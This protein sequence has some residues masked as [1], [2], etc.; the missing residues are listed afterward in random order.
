[1]A[2]F[3]FGAGATRGCSFVDPKK[4]PC[5]PPL[6]VDFF[7]QLQRVRNKKHYPLIKQVMRDVVDLFGSNF[8]VTM[9]TV[10]TTLEH[11]LRMLDTTG[12]SRD[13]NKKDLRMKKSRLGQAIA[14]VL[15]D[16]LAEKDEEGHSRLTPLECEHHQRFV[17]D[18]LRPGDD[19]VSFNY[20][21]S[22]DYALKGNGDGKWN[23]R[24]GYG[25]KL[26]AKGS[27]LTGDAFWNPSVIAEKDTTVHYYKLHGALHFVINEKTGKVRLKNRPYTRQSGNMKFTII[28]PE[29]H[30]AYD[31]G[32]FAVLWNKAAEAVHCAEHIVV[33]GYSMPLM[34]L[35]SSTLFR[36]SVNSKQKLKSLVVVNP[37]RSARRRIRTILQRGLNPDTKVISFDCI[38]HFVAADRRIWEE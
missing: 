30:K 34:D 12:E 32:V 36:T 15:E 21:C 33:I 27:L 28:P 10:F 17:S 29:W 5:L 8:D 20:D 38:S 4:D 9:E 6:D 16:S 26:G 22:L 11:T 18:I 1:M 7:T 13:F 3:V 31:K 25:F 37:D 24:Y 2:L 19:I 14:V 35:H 23:A